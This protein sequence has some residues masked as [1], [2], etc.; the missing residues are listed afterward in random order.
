MQD[1]LGAYVFQVGIQ[2]RR[3]LEEIGS[4][5]S[6]YRMAAIGPSLP[7]FTSQIRSTFKEVWLADSSSGYSAASC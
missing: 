7:P 6:V 1:F 5:A 4:P 2:P 3:D